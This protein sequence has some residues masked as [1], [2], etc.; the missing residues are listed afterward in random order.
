[1]PISIT[2]RIFWARAG[3]GVL[4][5]V[6][7]ELLFEKDYQTGILFGILV[8]VLSY[9]GIRRVWGP[10]MKPEEINKLYTAGL[11]SFILLFLFF[12][13]F[14]FTLGLHFLSL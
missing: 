5:G 7:A 8:Y 12:W 10:K 6:G 4:T 9:Y 14:L 1:M 11:P 3:L 13:I 2:D